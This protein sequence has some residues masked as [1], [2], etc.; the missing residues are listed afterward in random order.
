VHEQVHP[1]VCAC[2][3]TVCHYVHPELQSEGTVLLLYY[4]PDPASLRLVMS[5]LE[6]T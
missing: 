4:V 2:N 1:P 6:R 5:G 3:P